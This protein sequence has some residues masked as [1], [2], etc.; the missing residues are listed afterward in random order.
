MTGRRLA[1]GIAGAAGLIA[2]TTL[3]ARA[4]GFARI[5]VFADAVRAGGVGEVYQSVNALPNVL[6]EVTAGGVLAAVALSLIHI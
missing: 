3:L 5:L 6:F 4:A 1:T 2:L